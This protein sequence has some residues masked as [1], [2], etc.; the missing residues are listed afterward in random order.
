MRLVFLGS[1][2]VGKGTQ[3]ELLCKAMELAHISTGDL[4]RDAVRDRTP[5]GKT[6]KEYMDRGDLVPD[7]V[8]LGLIEETIEGQPAGFVL[9]GFP[10]TL[11]QAEE[12][13]TLLEKKQMGV[14]GVVLLEAEEDEIVR[15]MLARG[16]EDDSESTVRRRL[17]VYE[18]QTSPL[19]AYYR[20]RGH[21]IE[22]HGMGSIEEIHERVMSAVLHHAG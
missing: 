11:V 8:I 9:D 14:D 22:V 10:R 21:L 7:D 6:A 18:E 12:L 5:L 20:D 13:E 15:R 2:G 1:P 17:H 19:I 4:L 3:A 16:R